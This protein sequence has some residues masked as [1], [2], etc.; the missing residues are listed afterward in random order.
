MKNIL[1][2]VHDDE[3]Q[4]ARFQAALDVTQAL[5]GHLNCL[6]VSVLPVVTG[7]I[8]IAD[9]SAVLLQEERTREAA[10]RQAL[11]AR[12]S[13]YDIPW[14]WVDVTGELASCV[15]R[16]AKLNDLIV[17]NRRLDGSWPDMR[18]LASDLIVKVGKP[19]FAVPGDATG[20]NLAGHALV[21]WDG[22]SA[23]DA[24]LA[25]AVPMLHKAIVVTI[26]EVVDGNKRNVPAEDA[27]TYLSRHGVHPRIVREPAGR[28]SVEQ[29]ILR[30]VR[31]RKID[32]VVMG[33]FGHG[34]VTEALFGGVTRKMLSASP[35]PLL[36]AH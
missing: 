30:E 33:G 21:A 16:A 5:D 7:D 18:A 10:N 1:L 15:E 27:A 4:E 35:V 19:I 2:L 31:E 17:I 6:D 9:G 36:I 8:W 12:L 14:S 13:R 34:R 29:V 25:A 24:A 22:S 32:Y 20:V 26:L 3:G 23:A 11:E 28:L